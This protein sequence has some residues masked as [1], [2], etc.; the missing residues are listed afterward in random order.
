MK[1]VP[2]QRR[3]AASS[4]SYIGQDLG[5]LCGPIVAGA[6]AE[7]MGYVSMWRLMILPVAAAVLLVILFRNRI[8][9]IESEFNKRDAAQNQK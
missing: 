7:R 9:H 1:C 6:I 3:G 4:T 5:N 2:Q 8:T